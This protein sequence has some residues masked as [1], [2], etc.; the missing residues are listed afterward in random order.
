MKSSNDIL[1]KMLAQETSKQP[2]E[3]LET[4]SQTECVQ[5]NPDV[6]ELINYLY[7]QEKQ[8]TTYTHN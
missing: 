2:K 8:Y 6:F 7:H 3:L 5:R 1:Y 4:I